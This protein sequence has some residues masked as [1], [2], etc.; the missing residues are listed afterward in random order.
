[1]KFLA[2]LKDSLREAMDTKVIYFTLGLSVL[3]I[4]LT[5]SLSFRPVPVDEQ[6]R[7]FTRTMT[8]EL[9]GRSHNSH[10]VAWLLMW[11]S[12]FSPVVLGSFFLCFST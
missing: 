12:S 8:C 7:D 3:L 9:C 1:M 10:N 4:L 6:V 11:P 2:I 5:A